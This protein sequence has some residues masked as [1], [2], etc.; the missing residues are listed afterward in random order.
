MVSGPATSYTWD[1]V[2]GLPVV[3]Q[4]ST[5]TYAYGL[6]LISAIDG[7]GAQT[8]FT[9]D[10]LG[11]TADLE[12]QLGAD[13]PVSGELLSRLAEDDFH[14]AVVEVDALDGA[15]HDIR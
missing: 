10:G 15:L 13:A 6:D 11:S 2:G 1:A 9:Y 14:A 4:D 7:T 3:L 8:Y 12:T 5:K